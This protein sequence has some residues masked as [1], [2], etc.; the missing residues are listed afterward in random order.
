MP[1]EWKL[2][3]PGHW[4]KSWLVQKFICSISKFLLYLLF[5]VL[6]NH[7]EWY[8]STH[9]ALCCKFDKDP[10]LQKHW[11]W[12]AMSPVMSVFGHWDINVFPRVFVALLDRFTS[13]T[14][15]E[16]AI[17]RQVI[18]SVDAT[19]PL[20]YN[21]GCSILLSEIYST[22]FARRSSL[23]SQFFLFVTWSSASKNHL[24]CVR[25]NRC[26]LLY[27]NFGGTSEGG[28]EHGLDNVAYLADD[29]L[30]TGDLSLSGLLELLAHI[31]VWNLIVPFCKIIEKKDNRN[32]LA[33]NYSTWF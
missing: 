10:K 20:V 19:I 32:S 16:Q 31:I 9:L 14:T 24:C 7:L 6:F 30:I 2:R 11:T 23:T 3:L 28:W 5:P 8:V 29:I 18:N 12:R 25:V 33:V 15:S 22:N 1:V 4:T 21:G 13:D 27:W 17:L 26:F